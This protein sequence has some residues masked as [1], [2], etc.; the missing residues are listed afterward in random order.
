MQELVP[1]DINPFVAEVFLQ[2]TLSSHEGLM[3]LVAGRIA[4]GIEGFEPSELVDEDAA[5]ESAW[6]YVLYTEDGD[7]QAETYSTDHVMDVGQY[8]VRGFMRE[9]IAL[10]R[11]QNFENVAGRIQKQLAN[12]LQ[13]VAQCETSG[14]W[15]GT[16]HECQMLKEKHKRTYGER[17]RRICEMGIRVRISTT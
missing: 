10:A 15:A 13:G 11:G 4:P 2:N 17:G 14:E 1:N 6:P 5:P 7:V 16:V 3:A 9:D 12:A 8:L